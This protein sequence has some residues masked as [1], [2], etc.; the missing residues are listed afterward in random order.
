MNQNILDILKK[1]K[2]VFLKEDGFEIIGV[3]GSCARGEDGSDSDVDIL[4][5]VHQ[6]FLEKYGGFQAFHQLNNIRQKLQNALHRD[7]DLATIDSHNE[8][9]RKFAFKDIVYVQ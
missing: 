4:Y 2:K 7:V 9:F 1:N 6:K 3:F 5:T 8:T